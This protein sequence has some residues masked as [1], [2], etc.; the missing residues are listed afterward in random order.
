MLL[1]FNDIIGYVCIILVRFFAG[2][3]FKHLELTFISKTSLTMHEVMK[4]R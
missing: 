3:T 4:I 1:T 2:F